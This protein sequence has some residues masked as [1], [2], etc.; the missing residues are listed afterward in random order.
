MSTRNR[1]PATDDAPPLLAAGRLAVHRPADG[2]VL[3]APVDVRIGD[4]QV[5]AVTGPSGAGKSTLL[6]ALLDVLPRGL[7]RSGGTVSWQ[8]KPV[9]RGR[10]ARRWRRRHCGRLGQDPGASLHPLWSVE[11]LIGEELH[12]DRRARAERVHTLL[13]TLGLAPH[14][15]SRRAG[16]LSGGQAQR[17]ALARALA[18]D[19][20]LLVL[21]EPTSAM[22]RATGDLVI[23]AVR[24]HRGRP[25]R[26]VLL[27]THDARLAAELGDTTLHIESAAGMHTGPAETA[28]PGPARAVRTSARTRRA[29]VD[30]PRHAAV[31]ETRVIGPEEP[32]ATPAPLTGLRTSAR[33]SPPPVVPRVSSSAPAGFPPAG[34][35][36]SSPVLAARGLRLTTPDGTPL[37]D[38]WD[39]EL[40]AGGS[41]AVMGSSGS[42]KTTLLHALTGRRAPAAGHLLLHGAP[43]PPETRRRERAQ[44]RALQFVGQSPVGELNPAHRVGGAV[45]RP[46]TVL[47]GLDRHAA[48]ER[49]RELI[50]AVGLP[51]GLFDRRPQALSGGQR[52]RIV[53]ARALAARPDVLLLDEPTASLDPASARTVLNLIDRLRSEG[54]AVLTAT[55]DPRAAIRA[56]RVLHLT[57]RRLVPASVTCHDGTTD[58]RTETPGAR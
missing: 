28:G 47:H 25:G 53:L 37:L 16:E 8:G 38:A 52:Q 20:E 31:P 15:A 33:I 30:S 56:D 42:G 49:A 14:L 26:C 3:L 41:V 21:D 40:A 5:L 4:G 12:A 48:R 32:P 45:A 11:R 39:L 10:D 29:A 13:E 35:S 50:D 24:S 27:V 6:H 17:V 46:L 1:P 58:Q 23:E 57:G 7:D 43:L 54:L 34:G 18:A 55:H 9:P 2:A 19:P 36:P 51:P 22:D 44:L